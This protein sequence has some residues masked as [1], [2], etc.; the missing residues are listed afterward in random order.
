MVKI[1]VS[2]RLF[3]AEF[4][5]L[6]HAARKRGNNSFLEREQRCPDT[7]RPECAASAQSLTDYATVVADRAVKNFGEEIRE[8]TS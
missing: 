1:V 3:S 7:L 2:K 6:Y 4:Q 8:A 5:R